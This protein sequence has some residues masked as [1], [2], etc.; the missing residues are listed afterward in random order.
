[1]LPAVLSLLESG[2]WYGALLKVIQ[3]IILGVSTAKEKP[4]SPAS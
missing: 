1:M 3:G 2:W 4:E